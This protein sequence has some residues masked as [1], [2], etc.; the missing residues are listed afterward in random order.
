MVRRHWCLSEAVTWEIMDMILLHIN[1]KAKEQKILRICAA[2]KLQVRRL[3]E[4]DVGKSVGL[5]AGF[6]TGKGSEGSGVAA[7]LYSLP[8]CIIFAGVADKLI[9]DFLARYKSDGIEPTGLKAVVTLHNMN[10]SLYELL[11]ELKK[12][13]TAIYM[14]K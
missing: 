8:D 13:R 14:R 6:K 1:D 2:M 7:A 11:E 9:D 3:T 10:W 4:K 5:L 12:E